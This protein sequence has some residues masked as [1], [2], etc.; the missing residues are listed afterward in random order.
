MMKFMM[1]MMCM[2]FI[3]AIL[4]APIDAT[5]PKR[6]HHDRHIENPVERETKSQNVINEVRDTE[7][8]S[9]GDG[10]SWVLDKESGLLNISGNGKIVSNTYSP[11]WKDIKSVIIN[12]GITYIGNEMFKQLFMLENVTIANSVSFIGHSAFYDSSLAEINLPN[13]LTSIN[14][15]TFYHCGPLNH[16]TIPE[17]VTT[18]GREAFS[19]SSLT[20]I[21]IPDSVTFIEYYAFYG[22]Q[23]LV[24]VSIPDSILY[25]GAQ[26]FDGCNNLQYNDKDGVRYLGNAVHPY[27][28]LKKVLD[29]SITSFNVSEQTKII[30]DGAFDSCYQ[31]VNITIPNSVVYVGFYAFSFSKL[32][33][34]EENQMWYL[35]SSENPYHVLM[36]CDGC[37]SSQINPNTKVIASESFNNADMTNLTIPD[38]VISIGQYA[39]LGSKVKNINIPNSITF[40]SENA[41]PVTS[42]TDITIPNSVTFIGYN[43]F[44]SCSSLTSVTIGSSVTY[45]GETVF[46]SCG[47]LTEVCYTGSKAFDHNF[48]F[49]YGCSLT[50]VKVT[51]KYNYTTFGD[52]DVSVNSS[53]VECMTS[54][55]CI[56]NVPICKDYE[57]V[58]SCG[59][60]M[61]ADDN[62]VCQPCNATC[63]TC[64]N[65][66]SCTGCNDD[67]VLKNGECVYSCGDGMYAD[68]DKKCQP[69]NATC[70]TCDN[71][72][73]CT[74]CNDDKVL[75][76]GECVDSCGDGM[77]VDDHKKCQQ[78]SM[79]NCKVCTATKCTTCN[80]GF[81][82]Q[83]GECV[84]PSVDSG[85][86]IEFGFLW[87]ICCCVVIAASF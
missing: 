75:K 80:S 51:N 71:G 55:D 2:A 45:I 17:S 25:I 13:S 38:S 35:G 70:K 63:K 19:G 72:E 18:I 15:Y 56:S 32:R 78:C 60:G 62:Y 3:V 8:G 77:Y 34:T 43:A 14:P 10:C 6:H 1:I 30:G 22:C 4:I 83:D 37:S 40:I 73:S 65:G 86:I 11:Y 68:N 44:F 29:T 67:K 31:L 24:N 87:F 16:I 39:F 41:F 61:Y 79:S 52:Q 76:N 5:I 26:V 23:S 36:N 9:C 81:Q 46:R 84:A 49:F 74:E 85:H 58:D 50:E 59:D 57:C 33:Y 42:L 53:C 12:D 82:V 64:D 7:S 27:V 66:E 21:T 69:C 54:K 47:S 20:S 28:F 48:D